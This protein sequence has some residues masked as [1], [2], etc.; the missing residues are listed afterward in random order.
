MESTHPSLLEQLRQTGDQR[1]WERFA[2]LYTPLLLK[3]A[4][5][6]GL[7]RQD[8][9]DLVQEVFLVLIRKLPEFHYDRHKSFR[10]WLRTI[11]LNKWHDIRRRRPVPVPCEDTL[12]CQLLGTDSAEVF[13]KVE[14]EQYLVN[15]AMKI[16]Q[17]DFHPITWQAFQEH[18]VRG[19]PAAEVAAELGLSVG[20]VYSARFRVMDR[21]RQVLQGLFD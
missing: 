6:L 21:M 10:A 12:L 3:W 14:Y 8:A 18:G 13:E 17:A 2:R 4:R 9:S 15:R 11:V 16:I 20:A 7:R 5:R 1:A 19:R